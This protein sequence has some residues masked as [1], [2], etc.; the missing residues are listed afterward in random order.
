MVVE[1]KVLLQKEQL[2]KA[3]LALDETLKLPPTR[4]NKDATIQRFEFTFELTWKILQSILRVRGVEVFSPREVIRGAAQEGLI[5]N[6]DTWLN[7]LAS[8]NASTHIYS[9]E[10][11]DDTYETAKVFYNEVS[12]LSKLD[13]KGDA[14]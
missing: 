5:E 10:M 12:K 3:I 11:A 8:R 2:Q 7:F 9:E 1:D 4:V 14:F 6:V 13:H